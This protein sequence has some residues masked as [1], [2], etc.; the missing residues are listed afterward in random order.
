MKKKPYRVY[1]EVIKRKAFETKAHNA[2]QAVLEVY[3]EERL[4]MIRPNRGD[5][6]AVPQWRGSVNPFPELGGRKPRSKTLMKIGEY[7]L[8]AKEAGESVVINDLNRISGASK[9]AVS[10]TLY[11][12]AFMF[13]R[14]TGTSPGASSKRGENTYKRGGNISL[15]D[16]GYE[17]FTREANRGKN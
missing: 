11:R 8:Q 9:S 13:E 16:L 12:F 2:E 17:Y 6:R 7:M 14:E 1:M 15:S 3:L 4:K 10:Q 5:F